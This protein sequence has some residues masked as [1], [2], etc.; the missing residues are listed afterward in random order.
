MKTRI[1]GL[2]AETPIHPGAGRS[3]GVIDLPVA[4]EA[5]TD[6]PVLVGSSLKGALRDLYR[7]RHPDSSGSDQPGPEEQTLDRLFGR[8]DS[9]GALLISDARLL[10]LP[11]RCLTG[12][13]RWLTCPHLL[14]RLARDGR[15]AGIPPVEAVQ[16]PGEGR[17][18]GAD[19]DDLFLEERQFQPAG[20]L[21]QG[22]IAALAALVLHP[23]TQA[24][25]AAQTTVLSDSDFAWFARYGLPI[26]A[27][28]VLEKDTK[29]S[30]NLWYEEHLPPD[31]LFCA[32]LAERQD[33]VLDQL[34]TLFRE[35]PYLQAGGNETVGQGWFAVRVVPSQG[36]A[37]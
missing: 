2:L 30:K 14:E 34:E 9:A 33:G 31:T 15:R 21:P 8:Q 24:R 13:Y 11:V 37:S 1:V 17:F 10:L 7:R 28:N 29:T 25:L 16:D 23:E 32:L 19:K 27:R 20:D 12:N 36:G 3:T 5:A 4:R 22:V 6:Y 18:L 35:D 26:Q